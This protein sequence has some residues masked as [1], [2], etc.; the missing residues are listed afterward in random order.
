[1]LVSI[2]C[3]VPLTLLLACLS[4]ASP[5]PRNFRPLRR[6]SSPGENVLGGQNFP[7]PSIINVGGT[8]YVFGT[9]TAG[10]NIPYTS[11][12]AFGPTGWDQTLLDAF[13]SDGVPAFGSGGWAAPGTSWAPDV[14]QLVSVIRDECILSARTMKLMSYCEDRLRWQLRHVLLASSTIKW[15]HSLYRSGPKSDSH[16]SL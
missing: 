13:P 14:S 2:L 3:Q 9:T 4:D 1:M 10:L 8:S 7:D 5:A 16:R 11:N 6:Q 12:S 15:R